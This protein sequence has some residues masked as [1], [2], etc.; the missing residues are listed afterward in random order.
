MYKR[1]AIH[2]LAIGEFT[3]LG[4]ICPTLVGSKTERCSLSYNDLGKQFMV[5]LPMVGDPLEHFPVG[6][7]IQCVVSVT[8]VNHNTEVS[9]CTPLF[10]EHYQL[11]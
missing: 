2:R 8:I 11:R 4:T 6:R 9:D 7:P 5:I 10:D 1:I 3:Q